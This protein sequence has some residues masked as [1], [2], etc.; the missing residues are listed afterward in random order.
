MKY[1]I[2]F[3]ILLILLVIF[4][5]S[6]QCIKIGVFKNLL[7]PNQIQIKDDIVYCM[8]DT[9][10][11]AYNLKDLT[12]IKKF[13]R[14]GEG[15][16]ELKAVS[17]LP[18]ILV[19]HEKNVLI[20]SLDKVI[21]FS[22]YGIFKKEYKMPPT[23]IHFL[24]PVDNNAYVCVKFRPNLLEQKTFEIV[25]AIIDSNLKIK[26][27]LYKQNFL[28]AGEAIDLTPDGVNLDIDNKKIFIEES[29]GGFVISIFDFKGNMLK[30][31]KKS[32]EPVAFSA[33]HKERMLK[34]LKKDPSYKL[35]GINNQKITHG[36]YIPYMQ[37]IQVNNNRIY[38]MTCNFKNGKQEFLVM[39]LAGNIKKKIYLPEPIPRNAISLL[40]SRPSRNYKFYQG[41]YYYLKENL[42]DDNWELHAEEI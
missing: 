5:S 4:P 42:D 10:V 39:D 31:I 21:V 6:L 36:K 25:V 12:F 3:I 34:R 15:P 26:K 13:C 35:M 19:P 22:K 2:L 30:R 29:T 38:I 24:Y 27:I 23:S 20:I 9:S 1:R 32:V 40:F 37:D 8:Q 11:F 18:N 7:N 41:K 28:V 14:K 17:T 16:G 33:K